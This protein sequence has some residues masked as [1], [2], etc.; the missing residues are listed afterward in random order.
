M[1]ADF[2]GIINKTTSD[3]SGILFRFVDFPNR[4]LHPEINEAKNAER[5]RLRRRI[6]RPLQPARQVFDN[7]PLLNFRVSGERFGGEIGGDSA[8]EVLMLLPEHI[9]EIML[10]EELFS[11]G[12]ADEVEGV[13][14]DIGED[15][16]GEVGGMDVENKAA[17]D[18]VNGNASAGGLCQRGLI[19]PEFGRVR[20]LFKE[21]N[22]S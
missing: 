13:G 21:K 12:V 1:A 8:A 20:D 15:L 16:V 18:V 22:Q 11:E 10:A 2:F 5:D 7:N 4:F 6:G 14:A 19:V 3:F 17:D 9:Y